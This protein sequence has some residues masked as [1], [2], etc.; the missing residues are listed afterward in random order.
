MTSIISA[1]SYDWKILGQS[2]QIDT[3]RNKAHDWIIQAHRAKAPMVHIA[4]LGDSIFDNAPYVP[5]GAPVIEH[6]RQHLPVAWQASLLAKDGSTTAGIPDQLGQLA[7]SITHIALSVGGN[8]ALQSSGILAQPANSVGDALNTFAV[9]LAQFR[10]RYQQVLAATLA[11][12]K[13]LVVCTIYDAVPLLEPAKLAALALFDD[14]II[15]EAATQGV[16]IIDL[17]GVCDESSDFSSVSPIEP[18]DTG[19]AKIASAIA[20]VVRG[21]P[22]S[23]RYSTI[24]V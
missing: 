6:L 11:F 5:N 12:G 21:H 19:G 20:H 17:R 9:A 3:F 10:T 1:S 23:V 4:L 8:D 18:S 7:E 22:F 13:P 15:R 14:V 24:Y 2:C 16:P